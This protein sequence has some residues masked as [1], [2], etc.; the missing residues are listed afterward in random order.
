MHVI[1]S[2]ELCH[3]QLLLSHPVRI[4]Y[5]DTLGDILSCEH[6]LRQLVLAHASTAAIGNRS[7]IDCIQHDSLAW[8]G[9]NAL[10]ALDHLDATVLKRL[11]DDDC[12]ELMNTDL[13]LTCLRLPDC[14]LVR[15]PA[16]VHLQYH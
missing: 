14:G 12:L 13:H 15:K 9:V 5:G 4:L 3:I 11:D 8:L 16:S 7:P 6:Q 1:N 10:C 2:C